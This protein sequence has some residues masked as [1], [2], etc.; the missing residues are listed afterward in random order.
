MAAVGGGGGGACMVAVIHSPL[1][2]QYFPRT[3]PWRA[4]PAYQWNR[5]QTT[6]KNTNLPLSA[7]Q[8]NQRREGQHGTANVPPERTVHA[9]YTSPRPRSRAIYSNVQTKYARSSS[10]S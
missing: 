1:S 5:R 9:I 3:G 7:S 8:V 4:L 2:S 10:P 6:K